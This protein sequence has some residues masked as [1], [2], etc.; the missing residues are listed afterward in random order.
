MDNYQ[1]FFLGLMVAY[2]P[3][4]IFFAWRLSGKLLPRI[5]TLALRLSCNPSYKSPR[6]VKQKRDPSHSHNQRAYCKSYI[7]RRR[8]FFAGFLLC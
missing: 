5:S 7:N 8:G 6:A 4:L 2:T 1:A 3:S